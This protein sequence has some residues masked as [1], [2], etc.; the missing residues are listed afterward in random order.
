MSGQYEVKISE[1]CKMVMKRFLFLLQV[2]NHELP[3]LSR[4]STGIDKHCIL[5]V[6]LRTNHF[7]M[8]LDVEAMNRLCR[9]FLKFR[10]SIVSNIHNSFENVCQLFLMSVISY[11][12]LGEAVRD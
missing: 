11:L 3:W 8:Q 5:C 6:L 4:I 10:V 9:M 12:N 7:C 2:R 1:S